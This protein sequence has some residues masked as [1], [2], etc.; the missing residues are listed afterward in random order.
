MAF[1]QITLSKYDTLNELLKFLNEQVCIILLDRTACE[2]LFKDFPPA[3]T[4]NMD[5]YNL[6]E[7]FKISD[8]KNEAS[9]VEIHIKPISS[10]M[11][12]IDFCI[13]K[14]NN[15]TKYTWNPCK[16]EILYLK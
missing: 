14:K 6:F 11:F 3:N 1:E 12:F 5:K 7:T 4:K 13:F 9:T 2:K 15:N 10:N 16:N 8:L